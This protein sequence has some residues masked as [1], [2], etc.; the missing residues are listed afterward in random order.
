LGGEGSTETF[1]PK[2]LSFD[3]AKNSPRPRTIKTHF[4]YD[5][6]PKQVREK[7]TKV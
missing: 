6:L 5:M 1:G 3:G 7:K 4:S 2:G